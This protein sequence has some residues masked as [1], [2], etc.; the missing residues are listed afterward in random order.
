MPPTRIAS[1]VSSYYSV[2]N[3]VP[4]VCFPNTGKPFRKLGTCSEFEQQQKRTPA[5]CALTSFSFPRR[6]P[7]HRHQGLL[8]SACESRDCTSP[9]STYLLFQSTRAI[10]CLTITIYT[11]PGFDRKLSPRIFNEK[12]SRAFQLAIQLSLLKKKYRLK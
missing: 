3:L 5:C 1:P 12:R 4:T 8:T 7:Q 9:S 10:D 6:E 2:R 11:L